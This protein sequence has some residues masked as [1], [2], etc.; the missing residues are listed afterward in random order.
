MHPRALN[1]KD[2]LSSEHMHSIW[3]Q[4]TEDL[5]DS[6]QDTTHIADEPS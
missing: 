2:V 4:L 3:M 6:I 1:L 5:L